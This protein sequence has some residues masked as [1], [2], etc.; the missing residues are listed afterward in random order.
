MSQH[1]FMHIPKT[2]GSS[3]RTLLQQNYPSDATIGFSGD[4][5]PI[6]WYTARTPGFKQRYS[7]VHG[8]VPYGIH[9]G[10]TDYLYFTFL[11]DPVARH[12]SDYDFLRRYEPHPLHA[13]IASGRIT[14][15][16]WAA[17]FDR[18]PL[19]QDRMTRFL[20][21]DGDTRVPD[22][23]SLETAKLHLR[24]EFAPVGLAERFDESVLVIA[25]RLGWDS[26]FYLTKNV[27]AE[28]SELTPALRKTAKQ[29]LGRDIELYS[30]AKRL[31][32]ES[33]E[34]QDPRFPDALAEFRDVRRW[35]EAHVVNNPS[36]A[37]LVGS[38]L[39]SLTAIVQQH[40]ST[41][42][43]DRYFDRPSCQAA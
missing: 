26:I 41:P 10:L 25:K 33:P 32:D 15:A 22:R 14:L 42:A 34:L 19:Y 11:R 20:S 21:G 6:A 4:P 29:G 38:E 43:L 31:F 24:R 36:H 7:L 37:F 3:V 1:I 16:D 18:F 9:E 12:F 2:A 28:R 17:I 30:F 27:T 40:R 39:P 5:E 13:D 8:H 35:L 23:L